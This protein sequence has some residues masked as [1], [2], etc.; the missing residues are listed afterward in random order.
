MSFQEDG[1]S[2]LYH[3][4]AALQQCSDPAGHSQTVHQARQHHQQQHATDKVSKPAATLSPAVMVADFDPNIHVDNTKEGYAS[5]NSSPLKTANGQNGATGQQ[6][7]NMTVSSPGAGGPSSN[8]PVRLAARTIL[9]H[10]VNHLFHFPMGVGAAS[11]SSMVSEHDDLPALAANGGKDELTA[12]IFVQPNVQLFIVN[13]TTLLSFVELPS[14]HAAGSLAGIKTA[15]S[16]V[17]IILRD[18]SGKFSWDSSALFAPATAVDVPDAALAPAE[19]LDKF[20]PDREISR[21]VSISLVSPPRHLRHRDRDVL[22][23]RD[24]AAADMDNL[25]DLL[26]YLGHTSPECLEEL[27][28]PL[29]AVPISSGLV[30][31]ESEKDVITAVLNQR[32]L[33][34]DFGQR[35]DEISC[36]QMAEPPKQAITE[37]KPA[38]NGAPADA[39]ENGRKFQQC[40]RLF[41]QLGL[42]SWEQRPSVHLIKKNDSVLRE[43]KNLDSKRCREAHKIA[44]IYVGE[45]QEDRESIL[46]NSSGSAEYEEFVSGLAWEVELESHAGFMGGLKSGGAKS[47]GETA[48]YYATSF[49]EAMFHVATRMP[50]SPEEGGLLQK[51]RHIGN[52]EIHIVWSEHWRDYRRGILPTEFCDVLIVIYPLRNG[53]FRVQVSRKPEVPYFGP[54]FNEAVVD[55]RVLPGLVRATAINA[56]R[57]KRSML[58]YYQN[59]YEERSKALEKIIK[60]H[61]EPTTFED[62]TTQVYSPAKLANLFQYS[63]GSSRPTSMLLGSQSLGAQQLGA[64]DE[65]PSPVAGGSAGSGAGAT[66]PFSNSTDLRYVTSEHHSKWILPTVGHLLYVYLTVMFCITIRISYQCCAGHHQRK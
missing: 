50:S 12:D 19:D 23:D 5:Q 3:V 48:P 62:F 6:Q 43:L 1:R 34:Q 40:R 53:L 31:E 30:D 60:E 55:R 33:E 17:R 10:L 51:T 18:I 29:N 27:G 8:C 20:W 59:H 2:L 32:N 36:G 11:L 7:F 26:Q 44:V 46:Y 28:R 24:N 25:D 13:G 58:T 4:F 63:G 9:S 65:L 15:E 64:L 47:A 14:L 61:R 66:S 35:R 37:T 39:L 16:Q 49:V 38:V 54:L 41:H 45:G 42:A 57:A 56:S 21:K 22:P 52:D